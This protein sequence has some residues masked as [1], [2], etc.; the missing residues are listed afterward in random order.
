MLAGEP[1]KRM[2]NS[3]R[4]TFSGG[5]HPH[6]ARTHAGHRRECALLGEP[7]LRRDRARLGRPVARASPIAPAICSRRRT[8]SGLAGADR[9]RHGADFPAHGPHIAPTRSRTDSTA[10]RRSRGVMDSRFRSESGSGPDLEKN[11]KEIETGIRVAL[12]NRAHDRSRDRR[13]RSD[14]AGDVDSDQLNDYI[15]PRARGAAQSHQG[16]DGGDLVDM[17]AQSRDRASMSI[18]SPSTCCPIGKACPVKSSLGSCL[19]SAS[20]DDV[21]DEFPDKPIV[22]GEAGWPSEGRTRARCGSLLANEAYFIRNFRASSRMEKGYDYYLVEAYDQPW[23]SAATKAPS[24]P[25]GACSTPTAIRNSPSRACCARSRRG[26]VMRLA[27]RSCRFCSGLLILGRM[28]RVRQPGYLVMG[29]L[30]GLCRPGSGHAARCD[31]A[32][33]YRAQRSRD[34]AGDDPAGLRCGG[35]H[36]DRRHR[37]RRPASGAS[38]GATCAPRFPEHAPRVSIHVPCYNEPPRDG[39]RHARCAGAARL[40]ELRSHRARQQHG[41]S[42]DLAARRGALRDA[43]P[44][45]PLLPSRRREGLQGRRAQRSAEAHRS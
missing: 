45:V 16:L 22:I 39:D 30:V 19:R 4:Q 33:I 9:P 34:D 35:R 14:H 6:C 15:K 31:H 17:A 32:R 36:H 5:E 12:A 26:A 28:P 2:R 11:E 13:Q 10:C 20:Y 18:S 43:G 42:D 8:T 23:K 44:D 38:S 37:T 3:W 27:R 24:A 29:A 21:Q 1:N 7:R 25:I 41:G 40:R